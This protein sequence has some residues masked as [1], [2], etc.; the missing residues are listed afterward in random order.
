MNK[1]LNY[2]YVR[3]FIQFQFENGQTID[4]VP[5][6]YFVSF[7]QTRTVKQ[8]CSFELH[9][10]YAPGNFD[11]ETASIIHG[12]LLSNV[13][14]RV[15]YRYGY[16]VPN[17]YAP[18]C[19]NQ[20]Y[21][22][23][24][25]TY[26]ESINE[27]YLEYTIS[28]IAECV[29]I[30]S[31]NVEVEWFMKHLLASNKGGSIQ[32]SKIVDRFLN[33]PRTGIKQ[34]FEG[35]RTEVSNDDEAIP[36]TSI[37]IQDGPLH[38]VF[39]GKTNTDGTVL[40][41]GLVSLSYKK[42]TDDILQSSEL[43]SEN[44]MLKLNEYRI[45]NLYV[46]SGIKDYE[47]KQRYDFLQITKMPFICYYDNVIDS[48]GSSDKGSFHYVPKYTKQATSIFNYSVGNNIIDSDVISF[49]CNYDCIT[50]LASKARLNEIESDIDVGGE[51]ISA[52]YNTL[53]TDGFLVNTYNTPSGFDESVIR[54]SNTF[55]N[56]FNYPIEAEMTVVGQVECNQ[57]LDT[58]MV[59]V[60]INGIKHEAVSGLYSIMEIR[61]DL[62]QEGFT[63]TFKLNRY[64]AVTSNAET[65]TAN[66]NYG[67]GTR[68]HQNL[69]ALENDY[70]RNYG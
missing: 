40:P 11:E 34:I 48:I 14:N 3:P 24:F 18:I 37:N 22:G 19:Q 52:N 39:F 8:A 2:G 68:A 70:T 67:E 33:E 65:P 55:S 69:Q 54:L 63:T 35:Y 7:S 1:I 62:S 27:G 49:T 58:I 42:I 20:Y 53:Q 4:T 13:N 32:P 6:R 38:D 23:I 21:S 66:N 36:I 16:K 15:T 57:L 26:S 12:L 41:G 10:M 60:Y 43:L 64:T 5:P 47:I 17:Q 30:F 61:D 51:A 29:N 46:S 9:L 28:G 25:T 31:A 45:R 50:A 44:D 59:N 56:A